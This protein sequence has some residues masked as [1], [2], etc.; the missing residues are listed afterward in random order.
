MPFLPGI[1][2]IN[3]PL[4][5]VNSCFCL[6]L[7]V[8]SPYRPPP[9]TFAVHHQTEA[10][11]R[12][13]GLRAVPKGLPGSNHIDFSFSLCQLCLC[14]ASLLVCPPTLQLSWLP[15]DELRRDHWENEGDGAVGWHVNSQS[16]LWN[17][18]WTHRVRGNELTTILF[19][20]SRP[21]DL[22][23]PGCYECSHSN[24]CVFFLDCF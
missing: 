12:R 10:A 11:V 3:L 6:Y 23:L 22:R 14:L 16:R 20:L 15:T 2:I 9:G 19:M 13:Y 4:R 1:W 17:T 24:N 5:R 7:C 18:D 21:R 8:D